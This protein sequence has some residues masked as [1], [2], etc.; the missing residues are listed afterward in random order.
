MLSPEGFMCSVCGHYNPGLTSLPHREM[1]PC[2]ECGSNMRFRAI[3]CAITRAV[4][5]RVGVLAEM[6]PDRSVRAVGVSDSS[7]YAQILER[8]LDYTNTFL[9]TEPYLDIED[10]ASFERFGP[11]DLIV[12]SDVI[13]HTLRPPPPV[14][15]NFA[16]ALKPGG[17]L[18]LSAPTY[19]MEDSVERY[20]S[21]ESFEVELVGPESFRVAYR[22]RYGTQ[23][24]DTEPVFHGGPGRVLEL[25]MI[26]QQQLALEIRSAG[27]EL[28]PSVD[29]ALVIHGAN[30]PRMIER[31]DLPFPLD[32][33]VILARKP[34]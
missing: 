2:G 26:S 9:H 21:L 23:G 19:M 18:V 12:C 3:A 24:V 16:A 27:F 8:K 32:G 10:A 6:P 33:G 17:R 31:D 34:D 20:P 30:W 25:R 5:G 14:L 4:L 28:L 13:E 15:R 7:V 11:L 22:T 29:S 1:V